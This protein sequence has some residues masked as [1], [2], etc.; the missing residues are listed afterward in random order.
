MRQL[1]RRRRVPLERLA[2]RE[3][4]VLALIAEG[5]SSGATARELV[6]KPGAGTCPTGI[7]VP[8]GGIL[9]IV[10]GGEVTLDQVGADHA[11]QGLCRA[12]PVR[13]VRQQLLDGALRQFLGQLGRLGEPVLPEQDLDGGRGGL[14]GVVTCRTFELA[15]TTVPVKL[16]KR[17]PFAAITPPL[18]RVSSSRVGAVPWNSAPAP[19]AK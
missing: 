14:P 8:D 19:V 18:P 2:T 5:E 11:V 3:R 1:L 16:G 15:G 12:G 10:Q 4:E 6:W 7:A 9:P 17:V 13:V